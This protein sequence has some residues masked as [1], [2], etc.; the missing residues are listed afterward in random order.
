MTRIEAA[1]LAATHLIPVLND[2]SRQSRTLANLF[3]ELH[4]C[5]LTEDARL[6]LDEI[7]ED[8][9]DIGRRLRSLGNVLAKGMKSE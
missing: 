7:L 9:C 5:E 1:E 3:Q 4:K 2:H 6:I 8:Q